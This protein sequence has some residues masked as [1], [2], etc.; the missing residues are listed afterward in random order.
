MKLEEMVIECKN[1]NEKDEVISLL[2]NSGCHHNDSFLKKGNYIAVY[3]NTPSFTI[4][5]RN[6]TSGSDAFYTYQE[7]MEKYSNKENVM[8]KQ[9]MI[10]RINAA[11]EKLNL[12][13]SELSIKLGHNR[14]YIS[15]VLHQESP[16]MEQMTKVVKKCNA[17][18][19]AEYDSQI[20]SED[21]RAYGALSHGQSIQI[22]DAKMV[23]LKELEELHTTIAEQKKELGHKTQVA[24]KHAD[25][26]NKA[27]HKLGESEQRNKNLQNELLRSS[28]EAATLESELKEKKDESWNHAREL[29]TLTN[30][31][32]D[33]RVIAL[34]I[35]VILT[36]FLIFKSL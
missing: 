4:Y 8:N 18:I 14:N 27:E 1:Q 10:S 7:F 24:E 32:R 3:P 22:A 2:K 25:M 13:D 21:K 16:S 28:L 23:S 36:A 6:I 9:L 15:R 26:R 19:L 12:G 29:A 17:L 11:K 5:D 20:D 31:S 34:I 33:E 35:I 30:K